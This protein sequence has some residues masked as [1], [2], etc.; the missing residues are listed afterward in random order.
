MLE[1]LGCGTAEDTCR[2]D[3]F[4]VEVGG[5]DAPL[6]GLV[7]RGS[8][9]EELSSDAPR[10]NL[11]R[12]LA[13]G[14]ELSIGTLV[15]EGFWVIGGGGICSEFT[16]EEACWTSL[17]AVFTSRPAEAQ[18][19]WGP[20]SS[21]CAEV[22]GTVDRECLPGRRECGAGM[23]S[24][25]AEGPQP[26]GDSS[27]FSGIATVLVLVLHSSNKIHRINPKTANGSIHRHPLVTE[28]KTKW[29]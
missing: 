5:W 17:S 11:R 9:S 12:S 1:E 29:T 23:S 19:A 22:V 2:G 4:G 8:S 16:S 28:M 21:L 13:S 3:D 20:L 25:A 14:P 10:M 27:P 18:L 24:W 6:G 15:L 7:T 26:D